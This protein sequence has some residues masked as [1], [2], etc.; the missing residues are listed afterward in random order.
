MLRTR[1]GDSCRGEARWCSVCMYMN[2]HKH[3]H[4]SQSLASTYK[5]LA[6]VRRALRDPYSHIFCLANYVSAAA[7]TRNRVRPHL[8]RPWPRL[9]ILCKHVTCTWHTMRHDSASHT[10]WLAY[11]LI[12]ISAQTYVNMAHSLDRVHLFIIHL[13]IA[14]LMVIAWKW[15]AYFAWWS[16]G[17]W[18][19]VPAY[20]STTTCEHVHAYVYRHGQYVF[21]FCWVFNVLAAKSLARIK[22]S[23]CRN[24]NKLHHI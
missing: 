4:F 11:V 24:K 19:C 6:R 15:C 10:N 21:M 1:N 14:L 8:M 18:P 13:H 20:L 9:L 2:E 3:K 16:V 12:M 7:R 23:A 17:L 22:A 5:T